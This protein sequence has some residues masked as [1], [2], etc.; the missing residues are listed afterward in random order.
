[1]LPSLPNFEYPPDFCGLKIPNCQPEPDSI[2]VCYMSAL[3]RPI[4]FT[5]FF[6]RL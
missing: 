6:R 5:V 3:F 4:L 2:F 1:M